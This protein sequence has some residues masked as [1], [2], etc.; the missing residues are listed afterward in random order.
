[1]KIKFV[2]LFSGA[3]EPM[4]ATIG[5]AGLDLASVE[6]VVLEPLERKT[7]HTG[8]KVELPQGTYG[9]LASRSGLAFNHGIIV[10]GGVI[11]FDFRAEIMIILVNLSKEKY[12]I[13]PGD[14]VAQLIVEKIEILGI[15]ILNPSKT[16]IVPV[17]VREIRNGKGFGSSGK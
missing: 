5:S 15:D 9:R 7:V 10:I 2:K 16:E 13:E 12:V 11:D 3:F 1:M 17:T 8:L 14:R 6:K 4:R